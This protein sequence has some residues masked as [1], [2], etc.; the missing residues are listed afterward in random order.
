MLIGSSILTCLSPGQQVFSAGVEIPGLEGTF[1]CPSNFAN[2]CS[3][4]KTCAY[5]CNKNGA[6][7]NGQCLCIQDT[8]ISPSSNVTCLDTSILTPPTGTTGG[9]ALALLASSR[10]QVSSA[11]PM[12]VQPASLSTRSLP[13]TSSSTLR[14]SAVKFTALNSL[15][16]N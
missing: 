9:I 1:T 2:Y 12:M 11:S 13:Q 16:K 15:L 5:H 7:I 14:S 3:S 10:S 4:K 8:Q 6:C